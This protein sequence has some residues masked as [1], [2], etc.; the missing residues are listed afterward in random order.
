MAQ[1]GAELKFAYSNAEMAQMR[2]TERRQTE[3]E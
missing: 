2:A 1:I 3:E